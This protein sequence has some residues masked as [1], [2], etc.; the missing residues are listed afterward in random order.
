MISGMKRWVVLSAVSAV[1]FTPLTASAQ[2]AV[3]E[4]FEG[5]SRVSRFGSNAISDARADTLD[6]LERLFAEHRAELAAVM[7]SRGLAHLMNEL[8]AA[9]ASG[10]GVTERTLIRGETF[11]WMAARHDGEARAGGPVCIA[12]TQTYEAFEI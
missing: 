1:A 2:E 10:D 9:I 8:A 4:D 7:E 6:D 12:A 3:C 11:E 5:G